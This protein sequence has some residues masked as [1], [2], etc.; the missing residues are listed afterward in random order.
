MSHEAQTIAGEVRKAHLQFEAGRIEIWGVASV[1]PE[2]P[3]LFLG[4]TS[5]SPQ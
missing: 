1:R 3:A 4:R 5:A 2:Q